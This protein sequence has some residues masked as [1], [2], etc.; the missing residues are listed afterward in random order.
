[1]YAVV[2]ELRILEILAEFKPVLVGTM[3]LGIDLPASDLDIVCEVGALER[4]AEV[5]RDAY[6]RY[7]G[8]ELLRQPLS[9]CPAI[10]ASFSS[11]GFSVEIVGQA[12][13]IEK[14]SA[15]RHM[16]VE[17]RLL[18]LAGPAAREAIRALKRAGLKTEPAFAQL[19]F[20]KT[21]SAG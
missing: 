1:M 11:Q 12:I 15:D 16:V 14:Q 7:S 18:S 21:P 10:V 17:E 19:S 8:F 13:P 5:V 3:P 4:F 20:A 9:G 2:G 6:G